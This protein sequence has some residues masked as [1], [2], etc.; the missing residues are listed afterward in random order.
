MSSTEESILIIGGGVMQL[1]AIAAAGRLGLFTHVADGNPQCPGASEADAFHHID[2]RDLEGLLSCAR[3]IPGLKGVFTAGTDF[4]TSVAWVAEHLG[5]P[6]NSYEVSLDATDKGRMRDRLSK[7]GVRVPLYR[8]IRK[9]SASTSAIQSAAGELR[10]PVVCKPVDNMGAR[11][12]RRVSAPA[13]LEEAVVSAG[14]LSVTETVIVEESIRGQEYSLDAL[15]SD[16]T[17][18]VTGVAER[19]IYFPPWFVELGHTIPAQLPERDRTALE[20]TFIDAIRAIGITEGA[21]KGDIFLAHSVETGEP[22]VT[23]GEIAA[24][25]SGGYMSGWTYPCSSG[26]PLTELGI[27]IAVGRS[28][29]ENRLRPTQ[30]RV[31]VERAVISAPG[32]VETIKAPN[33]QSHDGVLARDERVFVTCAEGDSVR[34]PTNNVEKVGNIIA[35]GATVADAEERVADIRRHITIRLAPHNPETDRYVFETGWLSPWAHYAI[36][37][38][39]H[40]NLTHRPLVRGDRYHLEEVAARGEPLPVH[41]LFSTLEPWNGPIQPRHL[42]VDGVESLRSLVENGTIVF[43][44]DSPRTD[45]LFWK[46]FLSS[47]LQGVDYL[48]RCLTTPRQ[49]VRV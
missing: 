47:G 17:V 1:P 27:E 34:G 42:A 28:I 24:R 18:Y 48:I 6:G 14:Q 30:H 44:T 38:E 20:K 45:G 43:A 5:L 36:P 35:I 10:F 2:L 29:D 7:A 3:G 46:A 12:V 9:P 39:E 11:G 49:E 31:S 37:D 4:S 41:P 23:V 40:L 8:V 13:E 21:A 26:I 16:G 33:A 19:H 32:I 22:E 15:V 25:L